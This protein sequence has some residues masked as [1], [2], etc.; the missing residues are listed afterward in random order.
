MRQAVYQKEYDEAL[1]NPPLCACNCGNKILIKLS[2]KYTGIPK[3]IQGHSNRVKSDIHRKNLSKSGK[4]RFTKPEERLKISQKA[5]ENW[6]DL[7]IRSKTIKAQKSAKR[8][9]FSKQHKINLANSLKGRGFSEE[10]KLNISASG[11]GREVWNK[12]LKNTESAEQ[13]VS[14][15]NKLKDTFGRPE[16]R[17][18]ISERVMKA[19]LDNGG[20]NPGLTNSKKGYYFSSKS[21]LKIFHASFPELIAFKKLDA[22]ENVLKYDRCRFFIEYYCEEKTSRYNPDIHIIYTDGVQEIIEVKMQWAMS[23]PKNQAKFV[24]AREYCRGRGWKFSVWT[25][26]ELGLLKS[27]RVDGNHEIR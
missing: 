5:K 4:I 21:N 9:P 12:G 7:D 15:I 19:I 24:A 10:H 26:K 6:K 2:H 20:I 13:L 23:L 8:A 18:K 16:I 17:K 3:F 11:L 14:R 1:I 25:E 27:K 22:E